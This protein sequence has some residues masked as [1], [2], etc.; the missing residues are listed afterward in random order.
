MAE[1]GGGHEGPRT[2]ALPA[3]TSED[4]DA[5]YA[6]WA[7][8]HA[9]VPGATP[10]QHPA[11]LAA[12]LRAESGKSETEGG[13]SAGSRAFLAVYE[14]EALVGV[15]PLE[16]DVA[17]A[18]TLGDPNVADY[19]PLL[20][21]AGKEAVV[22]A[23]VLEWL[24]EDLTPAL[25]VWGLAEGSPVRAAFAAAAEGFG[26][27]CEEEL[28]A[29]APR[30]ALEGTFAGYVASLAKHDRHELRRKLRRL[31]AAGAVRYESFGQSGEVEA[32]M[33]RFLALMHASDAKDGFLTTR[34]EEFFRDLA[35]SFS[36]LGMLRLGVLTLD[37]AEVAM[38][39]CF[40]DTETAYLYNSGYDPAHAGLAV[41]LL[42]KAYAIQ[43]AATRGK[44]TFDFLRGDED[45]KRRLGGRPVS[46]WRLR[47][48]QGR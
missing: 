43:E 37:G 47:L 33:G 34:M 11:F 27:G 6:E 35:A 28:E 15:A 41:G 25:E 31:E 14:G 2:A 45:Y 10:F 29:V 39:L 38:V 17:Q 16:L 5:L 30:L 18:T 26:W 4:F 36:A 42:S 1:G 21:A 3:I 32:R 9:A 7:A 44:R 23:G 40:E 19:G 48:T 13:D 8:L 24:L 20:A 12:W 22:A 46:I